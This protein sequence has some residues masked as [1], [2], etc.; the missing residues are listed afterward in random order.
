M[1]DK[2]RA[3]GVSEGLRATAAV[4]DMSPEYLMASNVTERSKARFG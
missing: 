4:V 3:E 1:E 2:E